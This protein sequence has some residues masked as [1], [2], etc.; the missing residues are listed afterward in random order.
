MV[1]FV[2]TLVIIV[3]FGCTSIS[4]SYASAKQAEAVIETNQTTQ[5]ALGG[6][7]ATIVLL[8]LVVVL[9]VLVILTLLYRLLKKQTPISEYPVNHL[10]QNDFSVLDDRNMPYQFPALRDEREHESS[11]FPSGWGW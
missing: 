11:I 6:Q 10:P 4:N 9:L 5:L 8:A 2:F 7:I 3:V 1:F